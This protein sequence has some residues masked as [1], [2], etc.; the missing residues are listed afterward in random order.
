MRRDGKNQLSLRSLI[1]LSCGFHCAIIILAHGANSAQL[2]IYIRLV[3]ANVAN[4]LAEFGNAVGI[5]GLFEAR[6]VDD[7][8]LPGKLNQDAGGPATE[9]SRLRRGHPIANR[10]HHVEA[11]K[12]R[13]PTC[14]CLRFLQR[15]QFVEFT[16]FEDIGDMAGYGGHIPPEKLRNLRLRHPERLA[17]IADIEPRALIGLIDQES[18][19]GFGILNQVDRF[20]FWSA[21]GLARFACVR[22]L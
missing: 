17:L 4:N 13:W 7:E 18:I 14:G 2:A 3:G 9:D 16:F 8:P 21:H 5:F 15:T 10:N 20:I 11:I 19:A 6:S 12:D 1:E 22:T